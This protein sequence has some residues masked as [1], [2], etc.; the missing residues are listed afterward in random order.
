MKHLT[1]E[2]L[3]W[4][5]YGEERGRAAAEQHLAGCEQCRTAFGE[6]ER[7]LKLI[8]EALPAVERDENYGARVW[9]RLDLKERRSSA[10]FWE[11]LFTPRRLALAGAMVVL[12]VAAFVAGRFWPYSQP[13]VA[14]PVPP[15]VRERVLL[16]A[17]GDHLDR[18]QMVLLEIMNGKPEAQVDISAEQQ[19]AQELISANRLYRQTA[20]RA[21][22]TGVARVLD[23]LERVLLEIANGPSRLSSEEF[24][25]LRK[26]VEAQGILFK[27]RVIDSRIKEQSIRRS[28]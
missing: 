23:E 10:G 2:Q 13:Q 4:L 25:E 6:L 24:E 12:V 17:V 9:A 18:S 7:S 28:S 16:V 21:G 11:A 5:Y 8:T 26:R 20:A 1:D 19:S 3:V 14:Q 27:V 22:D 15:Q